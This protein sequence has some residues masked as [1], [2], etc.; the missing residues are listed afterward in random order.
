VQA[1]AAAQKA[2]ADSLKQQFEAVQSKIR[3][4]NENELRITELSRKSEMLEVSYR[5]YTKNREQAR[6][7]AALEA[8]SIS[9]INVVQPATFVAKPSSPSLTLMLAL[10]V[11]LSTL[12]AILTALVAE[13]LDRS[14]RTPEQIERELEVPVLFSVPRGAPSEVVKN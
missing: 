12:G 5:E 8:G 4:L 1:L 3:A 2:E 6:I 9:N 13:Q 14:L 10:G 7:N 11:F